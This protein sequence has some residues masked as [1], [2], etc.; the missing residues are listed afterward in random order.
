[1]R[2]A[3]VPPVGEFCGPSAED[4]DEACENVCVTTVVADRQPVGVCGRCTNDDVPNE[5]CAA[6]ET[7]IGPTVDVDGTVLPSRGRLGRAFTFRPGGGR[8]RVR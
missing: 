1:L 8:A 3:A 2:L 5:G 4:A 7:C 6:G